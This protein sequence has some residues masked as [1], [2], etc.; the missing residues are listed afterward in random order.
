MKSHEE[1]AREVMQIALNREDPRHIVVE[2]IGSQFDEGIR[3]IE[4]GFTKDV[5]GI[6]VRKDDPHFQGD[7][8]HVHIELPG[9]YELSWMRN[10]RRRH[11]KKFPANV[12]NNTKVAAA[13]VLGVS[14]TILE[15]FEVEDEQL[16]RRVVL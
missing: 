10:G 12:P 7:D 15:W 16:R 11:P 1:R 6:N 5:D 2:T 4:E 8:L 13:K 14:P 3:L 9:G